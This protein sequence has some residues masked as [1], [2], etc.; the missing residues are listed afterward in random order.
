MTNYSMNTEQNWPYQHTQNFDYLSHWMQF[1]YIKRIGMIS[2]NC[3]INGLNGSVCKVCSIC[4]NSF[5]LSPMKNMLNQTRSQ[6]SIQT[7]C[8]S[9]SILDNLLLDLDQRPDD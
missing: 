8:H 3:C 1:D 5:E 2:K 7:Q 4:I 6:N 9:T